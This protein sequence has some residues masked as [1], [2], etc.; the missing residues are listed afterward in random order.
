MQKQ[1]VIGSSE[2]QR[3]NEA[4]RELQEPQTS[5]TDADYPLTVVRPRKAWLR[6]NAAADGPSDN[7]CRRQQLQL[8]TVVQVRNA[9]APR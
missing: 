8:T 1:L 5:I 3:Q 4:G 6:R 7:A 9:V 2:R